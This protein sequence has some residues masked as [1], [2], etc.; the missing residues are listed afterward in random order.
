[1]FQDD[2]WYQN[3]IL[4]IVH[5]HGNG[6]PVQSVQ[7]MFGQEDVAAGLLPSTDGKQDFSCSRW[8]VSRLW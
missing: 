3:E 8:V 1:M 6:R 4:S 5:N 2:A 7:A